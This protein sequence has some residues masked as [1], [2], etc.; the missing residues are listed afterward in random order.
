MKQFAIAIILLLFTPLC[1]F[2]SEEDHTVTL[3]KKLTEAHGASGFE[4]P[5][6]DILKQEW[7]GLLSDMRVDGMGNLFGTM[8]NTKQKP[9]VLLMAHMDEVGFLVREITE[10]G[11]I[12][13]QPVGDWIDPIVLAQRWIISTPKGPVTGYSGAESIHA[14]P[15]HMPLHTPHQ[16]EVFIDIGVHSKKEALNLGI[17]PGLPITPEGNFT[18]LNCTN[19]YMAKAL[20]DRALLAVIT[21]LLLQ[22]QSQELP[23]QL[24][25]AATVQEEPGMRGSTIIF[26]Q[27]KPDIV[28]NLD[29]GIARDF[30]LY[31]SN[32]RSEPALG[33]GPTVFV[34][35]WSMIPNDNLVNYV[36]DVATKKEIPIQFELE[37]NYGQDGCNLQKSANG[38]PCINLGLPVR[39]AHSHAGIMDRSDYDQ[40]V[41]L[42]T[43][44]ITELS[45]QK[46]TQ[47]Q[48]LQ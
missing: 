1:C 40:M 38:I 48:H 34:F 25:V 28:I 3:L 6:R 35:D 4:G 41:D 7:K 5:I 10:N 30:P 47:I 32:G 18:I 27:I 26:D 14:V 45:P 46:V 15:Q 2:A 24:L 20:D 31:F 22:L 33:N 17:R 43:N 36:I 44:L 42:L 13:M 39:Y 19:R 37:E 21:D 11:L 8:T 29:I 9:K 12:Y 23:I 16:K